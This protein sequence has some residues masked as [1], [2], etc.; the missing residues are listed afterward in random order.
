MQDSLTAIA[1]RFKELDNILIFPH[2]NMDGD[3]IGSASAL[4]LALRQMGKNAYVF[5]CEN[6]PDNLD[7]LEMNCV[8]DDASVIE[9]PGATI[10]VDCNGYDRIRGR[11]EIF[12]KG[13]VKGCID[14]HAVG[15]SDIEYDFYHC[16]SDSAATGEIIYLLL[17]EMGT[18]ITLDIAN[19][20]FASITTDTG[21]FQHSNTSRRSHMIVADLYDIEG[22]D[23]KYVSALIYDRKSKAEFKLET[24][25]LSGLE[26][27]AGG[28]VA[29]GLVSQELLATTGCR[30]SHADAIIQRVMSIKGVEVGA[31]IKQNPDGVFKASLRA[32]SYANVAAVAAVFGGGGHIKAAGC[33]LGKELIEKKIA[34]VEELTKAVNE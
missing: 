24:I 25:V 10:M 21:N 31:V 11:E 26:F 12:C 1:E 19:C 17:K 23:S 13:A 8:T 32:K 18:E 30:L 20:I 4:C 33:T 5:V 7:F 3:A 14:H 22:F 27:Y 6:T 16:E 34:L 9:E 29:V 2:I 15:S 28:K